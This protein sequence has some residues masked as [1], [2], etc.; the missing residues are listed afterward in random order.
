M[1]PKYAA[2]LLDLIASRASALRQA[3]VLSVELEGVAFTLA[4]PEP[5][6]PAPVQNASGEDSDDLPRDPLRDPATHGLFGGDAR[7]L[8]RR[9]RPP[10]IPEHDE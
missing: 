1:N 8:P 4:P 3:G 7:P 9:A 10:L 6:D 5:P 2:E